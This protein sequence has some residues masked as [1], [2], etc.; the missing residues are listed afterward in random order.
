MIFSPLARGCHPIDCLIPRFN[1][2]TWAVAPFSKIKIEILHSW[3]I[4]FGLVELDGEGG[5][6]G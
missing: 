2:Q 6:G 4:M 5:G 3:S 1:T